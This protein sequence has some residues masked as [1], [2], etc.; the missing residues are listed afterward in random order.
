MTSHQMGE[1]LLQLESISP[2][3]VWFYSQL[4][5]LG[6][7]QTHHKIAKF[8]HLEIILSL[9]FPALQPRPDPAHCGPVVVHRH[10]CGDHGVAAWERCHQAVQYGVSDLLGELLHETESGGGREED[11]AGENDVEVAQPVHGAKVA[12]QVEVSDTWTQ[13]QGQRSIKA[14]FQWTNCTHNSSLNVSSGTNLRLYKISFSTFWLSKPKFTET[15]LK[16]SHI[17]PIGANLTQ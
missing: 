17:C 16:N 7:V 2:S 6:W 5:T 3:V 15:D 1:F 14:S 11:V 13:I 9:F 4:V 10:L 12:D 8:K